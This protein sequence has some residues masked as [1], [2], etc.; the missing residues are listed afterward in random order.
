MS[1]YVFLP[2]SPL[3]NY[4]KSDW[5]FIISVVLLWGLGL[6][7]I[8]VF[9]TEKALN[10]F[11]NKYYFLIA[12]LKYSAVGLV[13]FLFTAL[14]P[15][16]VI[17]KF[18]FP[19]A[20]LCLVF[21]IA[22]CFGKNVKGSHR[23]LFF[24]KF[25]FQPSEFSKIVIIFYLS[26][27]FVKHKNE[28]EEDTK[29]FIFPL[30][31][32][33]LYVVIIFLQKDFSTGVLIFVIGT[34]M[35]LICGANMNW[36]LP[37]ILLA[38]PAFI[39]MVAIEPYRLTRLLAFLRPSEFTTAAYQQMASER[40]IS[41]GRMF[42]QGLGS[43]LRYVSSIPEI[44][45]DYIFSGWASSM[46]LLGVSLYF[47]LLVFFAFRGFKISFNCENSFASFAA[48]GCTFAI[49]I[50]SLMNVAVVCGA[51]PTTGI[52]LP[53]FSSGGSSLI[54]TLAMCGFIMNASHCADDENEDQKYSNSDDIE[55][56]NGV[57]VENE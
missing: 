7:S 17:R 39:L 46:G 18:I 2:E 54:S 48:F 55:T 41:A 16:K 24:G 12:Q 26:H 42:G 9:T 53:F 14:I 45:N 36:L 50:Q 37:L 22:A 34:A 28:Y 27:L 35:F 47:V 38:I 31:V 32:L 19:V 13:F 52:P 51:I 15:I 43:Y 23:W 25:G 10:L 30:I 6:F 4:H 29:E 40:A 5:L 3:T 44:Q 56:I 21:C 20:I 8:Y 49:L 11:N 33:F 57:V 1:D